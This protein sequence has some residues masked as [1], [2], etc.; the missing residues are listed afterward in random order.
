[1]KK[2]TLLLSVLFAASTAF[3]GET[4]APATEAA[5][6]PAAEAK[7][8]D[9]KPATHEVADVEIVSVDPVKSTITIKTEKGEE[10]A[11]VEGKAQAGLKDLKP[12]Q[13]VTLVCQDDAKGDHKS[14]TEIKAPAAAEEAESEATIE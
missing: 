8:A 7:A 14:V 4:A 6:A 9:A 13:K 10:T 5:E 12:G 11:A 3:A 2:L 1:M